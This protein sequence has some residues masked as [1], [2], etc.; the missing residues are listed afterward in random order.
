MIIDKTKQSKNFSTN[1][2]GTPKLTVKKAVTLH[3]TVGSFKGAIEWLSTT[4]KERLEKHGKESWSSAHTIDDRNNPGVIHQIIPFSHRAWHAGGVIRRTQRALDVIGVLDPNNVTIGHELASYYDI[5]RDGN[6]SEEEKK[7]TLSQLD[8]FVDF[9]FYL[10]EESKTDPYLEITADASCLMTHKDV[11]PHKPDMEWEY[12]Y[13]VRKM[14]E[15]KSGINYQVSNTPI[16]LIEDDIYD[17]HVHL[18]E[19]EEKIKTLEKNQ[20]L[21]ISIISKVLNKLS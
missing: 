20:R 1:S 18:G 8:D 17:A 10:E 9:M 13:V 21:L 4:P 11:N 15:R 14:K 12:E 2:D 19:L 3:K 7:A 6:T 5:N 16:D